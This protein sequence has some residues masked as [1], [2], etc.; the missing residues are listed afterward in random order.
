[1]FNK[2]VF[3]HPDGPKTDTNSLSLKSIDIPFSP[4]LPYEFNCHHLNLYKYF[5]LL[6]KKYQYVPLRSFPIFAK[7]FK[8]Q[9]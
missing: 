3:P 2:V 5:T 9:H 6:V 1:M 8:N 7:K 4:K